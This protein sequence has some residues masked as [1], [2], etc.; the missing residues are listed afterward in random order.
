MLADGLLPVLR[1]I[2]DAPDPAWHLPR[3][4]Q[5]PG[6]PA[7]LA[8]GRACQAAS[9]VTVRLLDVDVPEPQD[10]EFVSRVRAEIEAADER[11]REYIEEV[12][13]L[14][15][16]EIKQPP[17]IKVP[18][19]EE[20]TPVEENDRIMHERD[21][22]NT[23]I[24]PSLSTRRRPQRWGRVVERREQV[25]FGL[26]CGYS[27]DEIAD[28]LDVKKPTIASD[29][30]ALRAEW[31]ARTRAHLVALA[32]LQLCEQMIETREKLIAELEFQQRLAATAA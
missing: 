32:T 28:Q 1:P 8:G 22:L 15:P 24:S 12:L 5:L 14:K 21:G 17:A 13:G 31:R 16:P 25:F 30:V 26:M 2:P 10:K 19:P 11:V 20:E 9:R 18:P 6:S 4:S 29:L 7:P 3:S 27:P 23:R